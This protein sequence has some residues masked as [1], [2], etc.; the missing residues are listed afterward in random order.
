MRAVKFLSQKGMTLAEIMIAA[1]LMGGVAL[2]SAKLM[3][4]QVRNQAYIKSKAEVSSTITKIASLLNDPEKCTLMLKDKTVSA[5]GDSVGAAGL[6]FTTPTPASALIDVIREGEYQAFTIEP[7]G[8][9]LQ[10]STYGAS[11]TDIVITFTMKG[12]SFLVGTNQKTIT[13]KISVVTQL[14]GS[15]IRAC[16]PVLGDSQAVAQEK[17]CAS[18]GGAATW[19]GARCV[20]NDVK[21][22]AGE[23]ATTMTSLGGIVCTP[24]ANQ[25]K[26]DNLF[27][28]NGVDCTGKPTLKIE[29]VGG[30][31]KVNCY[32]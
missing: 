9:K 1:S 26:L 8:I 6:T 10:N 2:I 17:M 21:C 15:T 13:K 25:V 24:I 30:K 5:A 7:G 32:P 29:N 23:V 28:L 19:D 14:N 12:K 20:L 18:L 31:M 16:G 11:V 3:G 4:D 27:D 22:P